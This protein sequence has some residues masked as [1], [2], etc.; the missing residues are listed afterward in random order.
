MT[1]V[2]IGNQTSFS[3]RPTFAPYHFCLAHNLTAF[4]WFS[5]GPRHSWTEA[6]VDALSRRRLR[7]EADQHG[8]RF[9]VHAPI[10]ATPFTSAGVQLL[11]TSIDFAADVAAEVVNTHILIDP[12]PAAFARAL[13]PIL[14]YA[15]AKGVRISLENTPDIA[16]DHCNAVFA[17]LARTPAV[18][19]NVGLCFDMGHANLYST[20]RNDY[21]RYFDQLDAGIPIIHWHAHENWGDRD[22]HVPLFTGPAHRD[23]AGVRGLVRRLQM[24]GFAGN[25][26]LEYWPSD[27][28]LLTMASERLAAM[29]AAE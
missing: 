15:T 1:A 2:R 18:L 3:A 11:H 24:R 23:D 25:V 5:D 6:D 20:T 29:F 8:V 13:R 27:P 16:P 19:T 12:S 22:A 4:E 9:S 10:P 17:E 28:E 26:V 21:L 14:D 7:A